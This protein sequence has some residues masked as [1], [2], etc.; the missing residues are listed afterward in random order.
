M[1]A[2][3]FDEYIVEEIPVLANSRYDT[4]DKRTFKIEENDTVVEGAD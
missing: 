2:F 4:S 3:P 1:G